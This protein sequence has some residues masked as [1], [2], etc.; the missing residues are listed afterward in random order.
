[1][2]IIFCRQAGPLQFNNHQFWRSMMFKRKFRLP[3]PAL[4][5][6]MVTLSLVLG[7]TAVAATTASGDSK[8]DTKLVKKLAPSLSVKH[9]QTA[10]SATNAT[11]ANHA[12]T[13]DTATSATNATNATT[14]ANATN[15]GGQP[16]SAYMP[17]TAVQRGTFILNP[18]TTGKVLFTNGPLKVTADCLQPGGAGTTLTVNVNIV[19][20]VANWLNFQTVEAAASTIVNDTRNDGGSLGNFTGGTDRIDFTAPTGEAIR[21]QDAFGVNWPSAGKC[22]VSSWVVAV[23]LG[24]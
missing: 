5:I 22:Y 9:A 1:L 18:G 17:N 23:P 15:L 11:N 3:S 6:S 20:S 19:S 8:A 13:A 21:G 7:G 10:N 14:A 24:S 4:V 2:R 12:T 16:A